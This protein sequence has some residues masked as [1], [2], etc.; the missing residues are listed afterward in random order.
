MTGIGS[1]EKKK[2]ALHYIFF[3]QTRRD[4][5]RPHFSGLLQ[6]MQPIL[7]GLFAF[8]VNLEGSVPVFP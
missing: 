6:Y 8:Q 1:I 3:M 4:G 2:K 7:S 5:P